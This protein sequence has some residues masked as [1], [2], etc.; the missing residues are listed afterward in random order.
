MIKVLPLPPG[1]ADGAYDA[2]KAYRIDHLGDTGPRREVV[3]LDDDGMA[4]IDEESGMPA[5]RRHRRRPS[6]QFVSMSGTVF[7]AAMTSGSSIPIGADQNRTI[8]TRERLLSRGALPTGECPLRDSAAAAWLPRKVR[9]GTPCEVG[10]YGEAKPCKHI[11]EIIA[12]RTAAHNKRMAK[13]NAIRTSD[14][15]KAIQNNNDAIK[16]LAD[17]I[18]ARG[19]PTVID[20]K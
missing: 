2:G 11:N 9:S 19:A 15:A 18:G 14:S 20:G 13:A 1:K 7:F 6:R 3:M 4:M 12:R 8:Q 17:A 10:T 5:V 16:Q